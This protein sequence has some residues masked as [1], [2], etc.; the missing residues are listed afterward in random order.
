MNYEAFDLNRRRQERMK[1]DERERERRI[2]HHVSWFHIQMTSF[3]LKH[4][5]KFIYKVIT[6]RVYIYLNQQQRKRKGDWRRG[7]GRGRNEKRMT[8]TQQRVGFGSSRPMINNEYTIRFTVI[9]G[10]V[11]LPCNHRVLLLLSDTVFVRARAR[12]WVI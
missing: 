4:I 10:R 3:L 11:R 7:R 2:F 9:S 5:N 6:Q 8:L 1:C 12:V